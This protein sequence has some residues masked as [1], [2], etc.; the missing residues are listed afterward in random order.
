MTR[1]FLAAAIVVLSG[2]SLV[3]GVAAM[4]NRSPSAGDPP[5]S[6]AA[7]PAVALEAPKGATGHSQRLRI[8]FEQAQS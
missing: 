1:D 6:T 5:A 3:G 7:I 8:V 2:I 4:E